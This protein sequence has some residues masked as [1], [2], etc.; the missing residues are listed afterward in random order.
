LDEERAESGLSEE[1]VYEF[2][3]QI[4]KQL[5]ERDIEDTGKTKLSTIH[6]AKGLEFDYVFLI[7][8][9]E[10]ILPSENQRN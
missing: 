10:E 6:K 3:R 5:I 8:V 7:S 9:D 1:E 4:D 2:T